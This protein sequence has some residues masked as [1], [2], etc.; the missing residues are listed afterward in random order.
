MCP[1][2]SQARSL[3][4]A[5]C[6]RVRRLILVLGVYEVLTAIIPILILPMILTVAF[7]LPGLSARR[8]PTAFL[9]VALLIQY[10]LMSALVWW[11]LGRVLTS[12]GISG[13]PPGSQIPPQPWWDSIVGRWWLAVGG[14]VL[15]GSLT[16][17][18][19]RRAWKVVGGAKR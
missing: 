12:I 10:A 9:A 2:S 4:L 6:R 18:L 8:R 1:S 7:F 15:L 11:F 14:Y 19:L 17:V 3:L 5:A 13:Y 16:S